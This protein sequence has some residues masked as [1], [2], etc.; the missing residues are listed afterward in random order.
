MRLCTSTGLAPAQSNG[1]AARPSTII[2]SEE[3]AK[4][5]KAGT[6]LA[7]GVVEALERISGMVDETTTAD[8]VV[9]LVRCF[10]H[11]GRKNLDAKAAEAGDQ[12]AIPASLARTSAGWDRA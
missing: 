10:D 2:A 5:V 4:E 12:S 11:S 8:D 3:G 1:A 6:Q 9:A 7:R